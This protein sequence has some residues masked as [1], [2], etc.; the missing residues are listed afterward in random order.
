MVL[1]GSV[2]LAG[3]EGEGEAEAEGAGVGVSG[4][5]VALAGGAADVVVFA[6]RSADG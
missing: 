2:I 6:A 4:V 1:R 5:L 3:L